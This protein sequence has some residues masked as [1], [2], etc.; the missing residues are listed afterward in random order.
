MTGIR[1]RGKARG[2][3]GS[4][5]GSPWL[6]AG[7]DVL[8]ILTFP[9]LGRGSHGL[10]ESLLALVARVGAPFVIGWA[11]AAL[12]T[13]AYGTALLRSRRAYVLRSAAAWLL[14]VVVLGLLLRNTVFGESFKLPFALITSLVTGACL[15]GWR[16]AYGF[17]ALR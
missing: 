12:A 2:W 7:G 6:L 16:A 17:L 14:G 3:G 4:G 1:L 13:G 11:V 9:I 5:F 15:L 10:D 8:A